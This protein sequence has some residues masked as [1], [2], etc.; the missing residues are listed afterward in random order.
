M[1]GG[2]MVRV[3]ELSEREIEEIGEAFADFEYADGERG[4]SFLSSFA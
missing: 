2:I 4:M 1:N 3:T